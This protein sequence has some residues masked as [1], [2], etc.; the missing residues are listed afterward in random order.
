MCGIAHTALGMRD[1]IVDKQ[2][3]SIL[4]DASGIKLKECNVCHTRKAALD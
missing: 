4:I 1:L 2:N 3:I